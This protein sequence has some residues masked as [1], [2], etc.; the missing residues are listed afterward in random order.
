MEDFYHKYD[1]EC[2]TKALR[3]IFSI[4]MR[5]YQDPFYKKDKDYDL[6]QFMEHNQNV[7]DICKEMGIISISEEK[8]KNWRTTFHYIKN[9]LKLKYSHLKSLIHK[10]K[11][12]TKVKFRL[13]SKHMYLL[14]TNLLIR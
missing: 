13:I 3:D 6:Q 11:E 12:L 5:N 7:D 10:Q 9:S 14:F 4:I 8:R 1:R 2:K